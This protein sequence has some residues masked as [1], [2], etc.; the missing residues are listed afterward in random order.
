[1]LERLT[2]V[3]ALSK[4]V[5]ALPPRDREAIDGR[6]EAFAEV[7]TKFRPDTLLSG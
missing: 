5:E 7:A 4:A 1:M 3:T 2:A 6:P